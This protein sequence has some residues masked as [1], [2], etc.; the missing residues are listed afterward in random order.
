MAVNDGPSSDDWFFRPA[1]NVRKSHKVYL[2]PEVL[3]DIYNGAS[4][5]VIRE[6][7]IIDAMGSGQATRRVNVS[8]RAPE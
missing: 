7:T 2:L 1:G 4:N 5:L 6:R 3:T 8:S